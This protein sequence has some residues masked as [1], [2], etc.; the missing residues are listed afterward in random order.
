ML[1][2]VGAIW[3]LRRRRA[4]ERQ[5]E[6]VVACAAVNEVGGKVAARQ[7]G[8]EGQEGGRVGRL[9]GASLVV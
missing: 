3:R 2:R 4:V 8:Q 1:A 5:E 7:E 6:P 9:A